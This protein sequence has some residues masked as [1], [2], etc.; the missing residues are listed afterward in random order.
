LLSGYNAFDNSEEIDLF[1]S[2]TIKII[3][4]LKNKKPKIHLELASIWSLNEQWKIL[5]TLRDYVDSIGLNED[6]FQELFGL[7]ESLLSYDDKHFITTIEDACQTLDVSNLILHTK[8]FSLVVSDK[9]DTKTWS[10]A[11]Q[12]GNKFAF[13][14]AINGRIC[15]FETIHNLTENSPI[16]LRGEKLRQLTETR[17]DITICPSYLGETVSTIGLGDTF[18]AG[19]LVEAPIEFPP[20]RKDQ[21]II[22]EELI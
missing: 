17:S 1:L 18:T 12:N 13:A 15:D 5:H 8:Q 14:R 22:R 10:K 20:L 16:N 2:N 19:L 4:S 21:R 11:L 7:K 3:D 9:H 6:E